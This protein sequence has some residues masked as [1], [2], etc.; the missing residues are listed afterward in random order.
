MH[1]LSISLNNNSK[2]CGENDAKWLFMCYF[3]CQAHKKIPFLGVL[4]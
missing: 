1:V 3:I 4:T 2:D